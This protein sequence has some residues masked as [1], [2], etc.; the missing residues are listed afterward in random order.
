MLLNSYDL[1]RGEKKCNCVFVV[2]CYYCE[3]I[4]FP[5]SLFIPFCFFRKG[6]GLC[7][8]CRKNLMVEK[9]EGRRVPLL[10]SLFLPFFRKGD[11]AAALANPDVFLK[12]KNRRSE[13]GNE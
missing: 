8:T 10:I 12:K 6:D 3:S 9:A 2:R 5:F 7:G 13:A 1:S 11:Y 4:L